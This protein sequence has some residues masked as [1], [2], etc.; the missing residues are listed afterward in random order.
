MDWTLC[1]K[2]MKM[3]LKIIVHMAFL[4][5]ALCGLSFCFVGSKVI[6]FTYISLELCLQSHMCDPIIKAIQLISTI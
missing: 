6:F 1:F 4:E 5:V 2:G 3:T